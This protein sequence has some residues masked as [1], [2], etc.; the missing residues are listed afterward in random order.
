VDILKKG[1]PYLPEKCGVEKIALFGSFARNLQRE[2]S[3]VDILLELKRPL[4]PNFVELAYHLESVL[5]RKID[6]A[7]FN[8]VKNSFKNPGHKHI[9]IDIERNLIYA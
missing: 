1:L 7:T 8:C 2:K 3:D 5:G 4:G 9:A 6:V